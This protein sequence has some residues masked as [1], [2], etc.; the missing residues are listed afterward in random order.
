MCFIAPALKAVIFLI[1]TLTN[2]FHIFQLMKWMQ[3]LLEVQEWSYNAFRNIWHRNQ[4]QDENGLDLKSKPQDLHIKSSVLSET[5][6]I[7]PHTISE[8][9]PVH[10]TIGK[11][12]FEL[13]EKANHHF[14]TPKDCIYKEAT[15]GDQSLC[16]QSVVKDH[17][18]HCQLEAVAVSVIL[19]MT[20]CYLPQFVQNIVE[21]PFVFIALSDHLLELWKS[22]YFIESSYK[23]SGSKHQPKAAIGRL[24]QHYVDIKELYNGTTHPILCIQGLFAGLCAMLASFVFSI[25][26]GLVQINQM[27]AKIGRFVRCYTINVFIAKMR[28]NVENFLHKPQLNSS[29]SFL[30]PMFVIEILT[31]LLENRKHIPRM[32]SSFPED[33]NLNGFKNNV[34]CRQRPWRTFSVF[35][36]GGQ[37]WQYLLKLLTPSQGDAIDDQEPQFSL[38]SNGN[39]VWLDLWKLLIPSMNDVSDRVPQSKFSLFS[40]GGRFFPDVVKMLFSSESDI[41]HDGTESQG[42]LLIFDSQKMVDLWHFIIG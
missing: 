30:S 4:A 1:A 33:C 22:C 39:K 40:I 7:S 24:K 8:T 34:I 6:H 37:V 14:M 25:G 28:N 36:V 12:R 18:A 15:G 13:T 9:Q 5:G 27:C 20:C 19:N 41:R 32:I 26:I 3:Q 11:D 23:I 10:I 16:T 35:E 17:D 38:F 2:K 42:E 21:R 31:F 29:F